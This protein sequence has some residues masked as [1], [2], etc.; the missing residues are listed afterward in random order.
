MKW[1]IRHQFFTDIETYVYSIMTVKRKS[2]S[3]NKD[4]YWPT[5]FLLTYY[6]I[7]TQPCM[8]TKRKQSKPALTA[9]QCCCY[10][11]F[12]TSGVTHLG[13]ATRPKQGWLRKALIEI[14]NSE[15]SDD[16]SVLLPAI[17]QSKLISMPLCILPTVFSALLQDNISV[18]AHT[19]PTSK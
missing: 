17:P 16:N 19:N 2:V 12:H 3:Y 13:S 15:I 18:D 5:P 9:E 11:Q 14:D 6:M 8:L 1:G 4:P 10:L 7:L